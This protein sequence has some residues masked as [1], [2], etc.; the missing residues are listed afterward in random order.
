MSMSMS[1]FDGRYEASF[2]YFI[3]GL[4]WFPIPGAVFP[5]T[6]MI[7]LLRPTNVVHSDVSNDVWHTIE[8]LATRFG[9]RDTLEEKI[10]TYE[11]PT[12]KYRVFC[13]R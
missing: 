4:E 12:E 2:T 8:Q 11:M 6:S 3:F 13:R 9:I 5:V 1:M 7:R 10:R